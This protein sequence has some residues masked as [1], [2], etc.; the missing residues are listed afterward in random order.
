MQLG[1]RT[2]PEPKDATVSQDS[3]CLPAELIQGRGTM[4]YQDASQS[5][6]TL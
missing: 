6:R 4:R 1:G 3:M 2:A 5:A